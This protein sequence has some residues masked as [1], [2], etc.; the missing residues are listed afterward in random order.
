[1]IEPGFVRVETRLQVED[2]LAV[3]DCNDTSSGKALAVA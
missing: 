1:V 3:L 2:C